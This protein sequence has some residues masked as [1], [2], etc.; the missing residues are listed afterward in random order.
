MIGRDLSNEE[1]DCAFCKVL[2]DR[3]IDI[4]LDTDH[5]PY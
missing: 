1:K 4:E 3:L 5:G 2:V